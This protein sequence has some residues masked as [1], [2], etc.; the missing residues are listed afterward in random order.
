MKQLDVMN[1][2]FQPH[3]ITFRLVGNTTTVNYAWATMRNEYAMKRALRN[4]T[5]RD[6]NIYFLTSLW[7]RDLGGRSNF[8]V[9]VTDGSREFW[10]DGP[11]VHAGTLPGGSDQGFNLGGTAVHEIGHWFG[12]YHVF[13][14]FDCNGSGDYVDDTP[15]QSSKTSDCPTTTKDSCPHQPGVD[16]IHNYMDYSYE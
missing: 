14:G 1:Q 9:N 16:K 3:G 10:L 8:P 4:G 13:Q 7:P 11:L 2:A 5:Y 6:L 15:V 12:L